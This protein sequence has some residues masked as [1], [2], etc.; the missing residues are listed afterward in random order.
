MS[1]ASARRSIFSVLSMKILHSCTKPSKYP[2]TISDSNVSKS[3]SSRT[4]VS[5]VKSFSKRLEN[6][7]ISFRQTSTNNLYYDGSIISIWLTIW[8][9]YVLN[10]ASDK[11][12]H[13]VVLSKMHVNHSRTCNCLLPRYM[14]HDTVIEWKLFSR[15]WP[16]EQTIG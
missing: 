14:D 15:N 8:I 6:C 10:N 13:I 3:P 16:F 11:Y 4:P 9:A 2:K 5:V 7:K 1:L 12:I